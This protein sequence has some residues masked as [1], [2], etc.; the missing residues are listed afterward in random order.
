MLLR[1]S[2]SRSTPRA[3]L[4]TT[5]SW[6]DS[7]GHVSR[8][9][10]L[11]PGSR[12]WL[13]GPLTAS[14]N[15]FALVHTAHAGGV[16]VASP[17]AATHAV[18]TP[19]ALE[20]ALDRGSLAGVTVIVAGDRL[21]PAL[22]GRAVEAGAAVHHYY[23]AAELSF[24]AWGAHAEDLHLFPGVEAET[25]DGEIWVRSPYVC[26]G[27]DGPS[28]PLRRDPS[29]F[30]SVGD[31]G[32]LRGSVLEVD[33]RPEAVTTGGATVQVADVERALRG[34]AR[35]EVVVLAVAHP[36]LG[37]V[38]AAVLTDASDHQ[39]LTRLSREG[40]DPAARPRLWHLVE[41]LPLTAAGKVD[42]QCL[43]DLLAGDDP[44]QR[45]T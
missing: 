34:V 42:R 27:Y 3:V 26:A 45:L 16:T 39:T 10:G 18:L 11:G 1:T 37:A 9:A 40:L 15:L 13:P 6:V 32:R 22:R 35:G 38:V 43:A 14:M 25:R 41:R 4:R 17:D 5:A 29:G 19:A 7:F 2:G 31:R 24:V 20:A 23:G 8:L 21:S 44:P 28:G 12:V 33:G 30:V 36:R